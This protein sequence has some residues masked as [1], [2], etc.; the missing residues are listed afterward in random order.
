M[1]LLFWRNRE[2]EAKK[3]MHRSASPRP[4]YRPSSRSGSLANSTPLSPRVGIRTENRSRDSSPA[5]NFLARRGSEANRNSDDDNNDDDR[6]PF[7]VIDADEAMAN[8][9]RDLKAD[10]E[11]KR[12][13]QNTFTRWAN[14]HLKQADK[15]VRPR[16]LK[17]N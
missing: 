1:L 4:G 14:E 11:W 6:D 3:N 10:A 5:L 7:V 2:G 16:M 12:I 17:P 15:Q 13:Q 8:A 9:E